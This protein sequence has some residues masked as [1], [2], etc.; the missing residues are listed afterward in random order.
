MRQASK[1]RYRAAG[2]CI[3]CGDVSQ[4][5]RCGRCRARSQ[6]QK[7]RRRQTDPAVRERESSPAAR[8]N[9]R[10][11]RRRVKLAVLA[12]YGSPE[13]GCVCCGETTYEF[14]QIDHIDGGGN[15]HRLEI[16]RKAGAQFYRWLKI[17]G[18]PSGFQ[19]LCANCNIAKGCFGE[20]P[21][22]RRRRDADPQTC[23]PRVD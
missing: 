1:D 19:V 9:M 13:G 16:R 17:K 12:H 11:V 23:Q 10:D 18:Y 5:V 20:C 21:H 3:D 2:L 6:A 8:A 15:A 7:T 14:L 4:M 22:E